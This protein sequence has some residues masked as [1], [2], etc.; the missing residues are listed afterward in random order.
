MSPLLWFTHFHSMAFHTKDTRYIEVFL[1]FCL[2]LSVYLYP[3]REPKLVE[4]D[5]HNS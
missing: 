4:I 2:G 1:E 5:V 3:D